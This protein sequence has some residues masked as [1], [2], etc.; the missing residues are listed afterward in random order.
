MTILDDLR[1]AIQQTKPIVYYVTGEHVTQGKAYQ[2]GPVGVFPEVWHF[3]PV[4]FEAKKAEL[5]RYCR[6]VDFRTWR[7]SP[8]DIARR[9]IPFEEPHDNHPTTTTDHE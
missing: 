6:L 5:S 1:A 3:H 7:P 8:E 2:I 9:P 4:D